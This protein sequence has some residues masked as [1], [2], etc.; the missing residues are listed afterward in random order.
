M[1]TIDMYFIYFLENKVQVALFFDMVTIGCKNML[2][3][4][5]YLFV[6]MIFLIV[7]LRPIQIN[8]IFIFCRK[9]KKLQHTII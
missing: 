5:G 8:K 7:N 2:R 6:N 1:Y 9:Y 4:I 3:H